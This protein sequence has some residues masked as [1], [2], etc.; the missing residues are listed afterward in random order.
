MND[1]PLS[2]ETRGPHIDP[3]VQGRVPGLPPFP[4]LGAWQSRRTLASAPFVPP[5]WVRE[6]LTGAHPFWY[7]F[8]ELTLAASE[9]KLTRISTSE[10]FWVLAILSH[11][12]PEGQ[13]AVGPA[14][15]FRVQIYEDIGA[16]K[17]MKYGVNQGN[18]AP[19]A[20]EPMLQRVL[21]FIAAGSPVNCRVQNLL[22]AQN[23]V[24]ICLFG[25]SGLWRK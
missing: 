6:S 15:S 2:G 11:G 1:G 20:R 19:N 3:W 18:C 23:V 14:G 22:A 8:P 10:D 13:V 16:Y 24:N 5:Q 4:P 25:Y 12:M 17:W 9:T 21:H 7:Q